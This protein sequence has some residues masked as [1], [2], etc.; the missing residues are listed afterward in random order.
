VKPALPE[1]RGLDPLSLNAWE[2]RLAAVV[3]LP[4][5]NLDC[6]AC[7][8]PYLKPRAT[9]GESIGLDAVLDAIYV[10]RRWIDGVV[11]RGGEP[12]LHLGLLELLATLAEFG[13][14]V[15]LVT[16]GTRPDRLGEIVRRE[17]VDL[18]SLH[19]KAPLNEK[20]AAACGGPVDLASVYASIELLLAGDV[21]YEFR[22][23]YDARLLTERDV[24]SLARTLSG[25]R[26]LVLSGDD[27]V[28]LRRLADEVARHVQAC[29]VDG[30][31]TR[32]EGTL[33]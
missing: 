19:L 17:L 18:V 2:G 3:Y 22:I 26:R 5:C 10:R 12:L 24:H 7:P 9:A 21:P 14:S 29:V 30:S 13:L 16:N 25:A 33:V 1:I 27:H 32:R 28:S 11:V 31:V 20:Y 8:V 23:A 15:K 6:P 4:G